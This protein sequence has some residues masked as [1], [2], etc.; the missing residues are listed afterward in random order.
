MQQPSQEERVRECK[1][2]RVHECNQGK[3]QQ[4]N[5]NSNNS[6]YKSAN[7]TGTSLFILMYA[8]KRIVL[9]YK[10]E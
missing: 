9:A 7:N 2:N 10:G 4:L 5:D 3:P 8:T 6:D 1:D